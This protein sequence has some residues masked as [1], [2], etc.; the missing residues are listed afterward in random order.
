MVKPILK[1]CFCTMCINFWYAMEINPPSLAALPYF[2][3]KFQRDIFQYVLNIFQI[4]MYP[5]QITVSPVF[6]YMFDT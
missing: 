1:Y 5:N 6:K 4:Y 2:Q 3:C